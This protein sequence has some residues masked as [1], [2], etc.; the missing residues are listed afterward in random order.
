MYS[1]HSNLELN[2]EIAHKKKHEPEQKHYP[3][4][5]YLELALPFIVHKRTH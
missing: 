1:K 4:P 3:K 2:I 5:F